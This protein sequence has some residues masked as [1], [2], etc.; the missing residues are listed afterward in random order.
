M[1]MPKVI[2]QIINNCFQ[3]PNVLYG[4]SIK[5]DALC[6]IRW[7]DGDD[8]YIKNVW[9]IPEWCPLKDLEDNK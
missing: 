3:C 2:T 1:I 5:D 6:G 9:M 4:S 8:N 7:N